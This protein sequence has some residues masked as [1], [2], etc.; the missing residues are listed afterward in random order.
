[1]P[2][3]NCSE[4]SKPSFPSKSESEEEKH[5][6]SC[7]PSFFVWIPLLLPSFTFY[8]LSQYP[9]LFSFLG[10]CP[11]SCFVFF[12]LSLWLTKFMWQQRCQKN[13]FILVYLFFFLATK[14]LEGSIF[15]VRPLTDG[16]FVH[17][18]SVFFNLSCIRLISHG[19]WSESQR[20]IPKDEK[21]K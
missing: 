5:I 3:R 4:F 21:F 16:S 9:F 8:F 12:R 15:F 17:F 20:Y 6:F 1:M 10:I 18:L 13:M 2:N 7:F 14:S 19:V 11:N